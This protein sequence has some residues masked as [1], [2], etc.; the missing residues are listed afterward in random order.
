MRI[1]FNQLRP[2]YDFVIVGAGIVGITIATELV[3]KG[4]ANILLLEA[5]SDHSINPYPQVQ[6][7]NSNGSIKRKSTFVG[8]GGGSNVWGTISGLLDKKRVNSYYERGL[9]PIN[10]LQYLKYVKLTE[11][12][13]FP[14][15]KLFE[16]RTCIN[17]T[18]RAKKFVKKI[19]NIRFKNNCTVIEGNNIDYIANVRAEKIVE[20]KLKVVSKNDAK[21]ISSKRIILCANTLQNISILSSSNIPDIAPTLGRKFMNHP[22]G[23]IGSIRISVELKKFIIPLPL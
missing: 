14:S 12:Y 7:V 17:D 21:V 23:V 6:K 13:G 16:D 11:K 5:G 22:K 20:N 1:K 10:Y 3:Q 8:L 19:P 2:E 18:I 4:K 9:F 15:H